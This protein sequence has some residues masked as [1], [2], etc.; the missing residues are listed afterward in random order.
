ANIGH[1]FSLKLTR[2]PRGM[3]G[4]VAGVE[5]APPGGKPGTLPLS[6]TRITRNLQEAY[7]R[8]H[9]RNA[10]PL[11]IPRERGLPARFCRARLTDEGGNTGRLAF[12]QIAHDEAA[13][14]RTH[15]SALDMLNL[16]GMITCGQREGFRTPP[17][18][19]GLGFIWACLMLRRQPCCV[20]GIVHARL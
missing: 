14:C 8:E 1:C 6:Y 12:N 13:D 18:T 15:I 4:R 9:D 11:Q 16:A 17:K 3:L 10:P 5:P 19:W 20:M 7:I 2:D